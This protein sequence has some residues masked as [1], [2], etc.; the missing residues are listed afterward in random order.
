[1]DGY[2]F[3]PDG[4]HSRET[5]KARYDDRYTLYGVRGNLPQKPIAFNDRI[6][7]NRKL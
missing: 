2:D 6:V 7:S 5:E 4:R 3:R 1:M